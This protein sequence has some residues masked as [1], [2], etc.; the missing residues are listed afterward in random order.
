[1]ASEFRV[2]ADAT[3]QAN[4]N[5]RDPIELKIDDWLDYWTSLKINALLLNA[6]RILTF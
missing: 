6:G 5:E 2:P 1:V 4:F 3:R